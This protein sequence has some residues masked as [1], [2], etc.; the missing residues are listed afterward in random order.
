MSCD[1]CGSATH[2]PDECETVAPEPEEEDL[3]RVFEE[4]LEAQLEDDLAA[5]FETQLRAWMARANDGDGRPGKESPRS[6]LP[7]VKVSTALAEVIDSA[8]AVLADDPDVYVRDYKL[9]HVTRVSPLEAQASRDV[10]LTNEDGSY[11][12]R[13]SLVAGTPRIHPMEIPTLRERL[14]RVAR[15]EK[16]KDDD[17]I[18]RIPSDPIVT[19]LAARK[20]W[21]YLR[22]IVGIAEAPFMRPDGTICQTPGYDVATG[23]EYIPAQGCKFEKVPDAPT[24]AEAARAYE[25]VA[26]EL[27]G[28]FMFDPK[29]AAVPLAGAL[30]ILARP[31]ILGST[32]IFVFDGNVAGVGKTLITD[33]IALIA[34]GRPMPR[35]NYPGAEEEQEKL[36]AGYA[37]QGAT[38]FSLD[39]I[40]AGTPFG[41][42]P[43]NRVTTSGGSVQLRVLGRNSVPTVTWLAVIFATGNNIE[44]KG[45]MPPRVLVARQESTLEDPRTRTGFRHEDLIGW[46]RMNRSW[47]V[48]HLLTILR[49]YVV[50]RRDKRKDVAAIVPKRWGSF[51]SWSSLIP[52]ALVYAGAPDPMGARIKDIASVSDEHRQLAGILE[53][54]QALVACVSRADRVSWSTKR[55][56][57]KPARRWGLTAGEAIHAL[58]DGGAQGDSTFDGLRGAIEA[59]CCPRRAS[60][61]VR[62]TSVALGCR[63]RGF[64]HRVV[65]TNRFTSRTDRT[66]VEIWA[67]EDASAEPPDNVVDITAK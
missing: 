46:T 66:R 58:Y 22:P 60:G 6:K 11:E 49:A 57:P 47:I 42:A 29:H 15:F 36:L 28:D 40:T 4:Q 51:E 19:G 63:L 2:K 56:G 38:F 1:L 44:L 67:V 39:D 61:E 10:K 62:P 7:I 21:R 34:S 12:M 54:W 32:P 45:D 64:K 24:Q 43:L 53:Q 37:L 9:V 13:K 55:I 33:T 48:P 18:P 8:D 3:E 5:Q 27:Y 26:K 59:L 20:S 23:Y 52:P 35:M 65:G 50:A 14:T 30:T 41:G 25:R 31:A 17:W 16:K